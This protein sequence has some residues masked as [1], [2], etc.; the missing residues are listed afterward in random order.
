V[1][2]G[3]EPGALA[4]LVAAPL[5][6]FGLALV[7]TI[8]AAAVF[9]PWI[10]THD[11]ATIDVT[12]KLRPPSADHWLGTDHLGRDLYSRIVFGARTALGLAATATLIAGALGLALGMVAGYGPRWLDN[13]LLLVFDAMSALPMILFALAVITVLGPGTG[14]LILVIVLTSTPAYARIVRTETLALRGADFVTAARAMDASTARV[15][16]VHVLPNVAGPLLILVS[17]DIPVVI[18]VEAGLSFLGLGVRPP[19]PSWGSIL[20]DA[21]ANLRAAPFLVAVAGAPLVLATLGFTFLGEGL[22]DAIDPR[23]AARRIA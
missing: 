23:L 22:R 10:A 16:G 3:R 12:A 2:E 5:P 6:A 9:A 1:A 14:T 7:A 19:T 11:P 13:L 17:M 20:Y 8:V 21:Y 4:R 18:M 15:L